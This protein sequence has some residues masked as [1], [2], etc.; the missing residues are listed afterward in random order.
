[1]PWSKFAKHVEHFPIIIPAPA[2]ILGWRGDGD[3][4]GY[5]LSP[6]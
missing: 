2:G 3:E 1:V 6:L 5:R 4:V